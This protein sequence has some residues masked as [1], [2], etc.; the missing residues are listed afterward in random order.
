MLHSGVRLQQDRSHLAS[1]WEDQSARL[2]RPRDW[3]TH[4]GAASELG[5]NLDHRLVDEDGHGVEVR[6][7]GFQSEALCLQAESRRRRQRVVQRG[8]L[9]GIEQFG[10][11]WMVSYSARRPLATTV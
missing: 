1:L 3:W 4:W 10:R 2:A 5:R 7:V 9:V 8:Q 6:R 11:F